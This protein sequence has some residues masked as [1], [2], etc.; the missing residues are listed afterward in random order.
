GITE[1]KPL[2]LTEGNQLTLTSIIGFDQIIIGYTIITLDNSVAQQNM[3]E[4]NQNLRSTWQDF[5]SSV[6]QIVLIASSIFLLLLLFISRHFSNALARPFTEISTAA[7]NYSQGK[8]DYKISIQS[9][10]EIGELAHSLNQMA[11][12]LLVNEQR[13][14]LALDGSK[15]GVW[16]W[17]IQTDEVVISKQWLNRIGYQSKNNTISH[18]QWKQLIHSDYKETYTN[19]LNAMIKGESLNFEDE[20]KITCENGDVIWI[21]DRAQLIDS[22]SDEHASRIIGRFTDIS[23]RKQTDD[24][25]RR[26][27]KMEAVG[28]LTGGIAHDFNNLLGVIIGNLDLLDVTAELDNDGKE[29]LDSATK[30]ALR[31][32]DLT[33]Q[34][35]RFSRR[36][37]NQLD[38]V[39]IN[40]VIDGMQ[41][42][43]ARSITPKIDVKTIFETHLWPVYVNQG[44]L[45][46]ALLN[47][48]LNAKDAMPES[49]IL[50]IQTQNI[51]REIEGLPSKVGDFVML[52]VSD[53]GCGMDP[54]QKEKAFEPFFTTKEL[55]TGLG[56]SMLFGF[57]KRMNGHVEIQSEKDIGTSV[58]L[59]FPRFQGGEFLVQNKHD[60]THEVVGGNEH[61]LIV[62]DE[63]KL[64]KLAQTYLS[65][66]GYK[67]SVAHNSDE[68]LKILNEND[69]IALLFS[70][71]IMPDS[72]DGYALAVEAQKIKPQI[73][74][75][76]TSGF[77]RKLTIDYE[78]KGL[79]FPLLSKPYRTNDL[80]EQARKVLDETAEA[81][82]DSQE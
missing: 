41:S 64:A 28:Q 78:K 15:E 20:Y 73:K 32:A 60:I 57:V 51:Q 35:L 66:A 2:V 58:R 19:K 46:D 67:T 44:E 54:Q 52:S 21:L 81:Q 9:K 50:E 71:V 8:L 38:S 76:L 12:Q 25:L 70:D 69:D 61:V 75:L 3:N 30:A 68:A 49:G 33:R 29:F 26:A 47:L 11:K 31:G 14:Q 4:L 22:N 40:Q 43:I 79:S 34:L 5:R 80:L 77:T 27:Q 74:V 23:T 6:T 13:W 62:D 36:Q 7:E 45:E 82:Q 59:Y 39:N 16:D 63:T 17:N 55:G 53:S 56:L 10:D 18:G 48:V 65:M 37:S 42:L 1:D 72:L 24:V